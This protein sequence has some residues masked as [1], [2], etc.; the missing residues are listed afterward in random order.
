MRL[1]HIEGDEVL[2]LFD[3]TQQAAPRVGDSY[4]VGELGG[5][6][7]GLIVQIV[8]LETFDYPSLNEVLMRQ[9]MEASYGA[10]NVQ[11]FAETP[12]TPKVENLGE[13]RAKIRRRQTTTGEWTV[14]NGWVPS[15]NVAIR[16]LDDNT[17]MSQ[18]GLLNPNH[19]LELGTTLDGQPFRIAGRR[20]EKVNVVTALKGMGKS[21]L[22]KVLI[23]QLVERQQACVVF[24]V[25]REYNRLPALTHDQNDPPQVQRAG[26]IVLS[27]GGNFRV[28]VE[29]FGRR[30]LLRLFDSYSPTDPTRNLFEVRVTQMFDQ[31]AQ[32][33]LANRQQQDP[34]RRQQRPFVNVDFLRQQF[35]PPPRTNENIHRAINDRLD[36]IESLNLFARTGAEARGFAEAY[37]LCSQRGGC[38]VVD[39]APLASKFAREMFVQATLDMVE[40]AA[41]TAGQR[42]PFVFFEEAHLYTQ[43]ERIENLVTRARHLGVTSTFV[44]NMVTHLNETVM[45]QVDNLFLLY[46]PY[47]DDV[48]HVAKSATTDAETV[49]SF[50]RRIERHHAML[51]GTATNQY[52]IVFRVGTPTDVDMAGETRFAF[53]E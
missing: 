25:N 20:F 45:R 15:R 19:P 21:H 14:W 9:M 41:N 32:L 24:D 16:R 39:L 18:C 17:V 13:A 53:P 52:P 27:A 30:A 42:L 22:A 33:D 34:R 12:N 36:S 26:T 10:G 37:A 5:G 31:L 2:F 8:S 48:Q 1:H 11:T 47:K 38:V 28:T 7:E 4:L 40:T 29:G 6:D 3:H 44:T 43:G 23:L 46:L 50:A 35:P 51:V 49:N